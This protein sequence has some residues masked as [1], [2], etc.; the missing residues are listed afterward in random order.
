MSLIGRPSLA[1]DP[2]RQWLGGAATEGGR[3][4]RV[5]APLGPVGLGCGVWR[6]CGVAAAFSVVGG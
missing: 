6:V 5:E 2:A 1:S 4:G 3:S